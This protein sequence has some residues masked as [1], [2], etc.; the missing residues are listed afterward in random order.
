L[1]KHITS[2]QK[3]VEG[4][5]FD[6]RK[7][8]LEYDDVL[9]HHRLVIYGRR[10]RILSQESVHDEVVKAFAELAERLVENAKDDSDDFDGKALVT[11]CNEYAGRTVISEDDLTSEDQHV[12]AGIVKDAFLGAL[13]AKMTE[14]PA[15]FADYEKRLMLQSIDELWMRHI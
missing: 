10:N 6:V 15:E 5:N 3:Q 8:I 12:L 4:R 14:L 9:N 11:A 7:H 13:E 2:V 1:T